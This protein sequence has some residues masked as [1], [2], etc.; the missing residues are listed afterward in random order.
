MHVGYLVLK[1]LV[2]FINFQK[3][4]I[5]ELGR[6]NRFFFGLL[7]SWLD[8]RRRDFDHAFGLALVDGLLNEAVTIVHIK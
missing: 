5:V 3:I 6:N 4:V 7:Y 2:L 8:G 1:Q